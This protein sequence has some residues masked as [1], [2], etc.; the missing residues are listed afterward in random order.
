MILSLRRTSMMRMAKLTAPARVHVAI[1][2]L[3]QV[4]LNACRR[5]NRSVRTA[6]L[7]KVFQIASRLGDGVLWY[8]LIGTLALCFGA[9]GRS[10]ALQCAVAGVVGLAI[11]RA[12]KN[13]LVRERPYMTHA[14]IVCAGKPLDRFSF[15]SGHTLHAVSFTVIV[16]SSLPQ[17]ALLLVPIAAL[18]ALSRVVLGLHYPS[19]VVA[20]GLLGA[21]IGSLATTWIG[22]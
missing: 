17:L 13:V 21:L 12:L 18:I 20:G 9:E 14:A 16:C 22:A 6:G 10:V 11:Y 2:W 19:D 15:P 4:E 1:A 7:L 8:M 3:D 5:F